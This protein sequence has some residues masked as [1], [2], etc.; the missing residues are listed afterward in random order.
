MKTCRRCAEE[1]A[2]EE[3]LCRHC[4][5]NLKEIPSKRTSAMAVASLTSSIAGFFMFFFI[6]QIL[7]IVFGYKARKEIKNSTG[8]VQGENLAT[9]GI[10]V[11]W[12]GIALDLAIVVFMVLAFTGALAGLLCSF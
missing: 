6:G 9:A 5:S 7:G 2:D 12:V 8:A 4:E 10:I 11:G 3:V 1:V